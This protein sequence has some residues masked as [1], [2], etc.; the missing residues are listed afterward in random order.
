M[1]RQNRSL[2]A[3]LGM[4]FAVVAVIVFSAVGLYLYRALDVQLQ[5]RDD[6]DLVD[7]VLQIRHLLGETHGTESIRTEPHRFLDAVD[8]RSGLL[9]VI[10]AKDGRVLAQNSAERSFIQ[11]EGGLPPEAR[12]SNAD[13]RAAALADGTRLRAI[14]AFGT[15]GGGEMVRISLARTADDRLAVLF[16]Y[17]FKVWAAAI[18]GAVL[19]AALGYLLVRQGLS[20]VRAMAAQAQQVTAHNLEMRLSAE[21]APAELRV[22]ADSFNA[23]LDRLQNSFNHLSQF[24]D[25]LAH[26]L[27]TPLNNLMVQTEVAF[28]QPRQ[29]EEYQHLLSSNYEEFGRLARMVESML[30]L[31]RADHDQVLL[32]TEMLDVATELAMI[33]EYFEGPASEANVSFQITANGGVL[34]DSQ[35]LRRAVSNLVANA[36]RYTPGHGVIALGATQGPDGVTISVTN[37]GVG[38]EADHLPRLFDRFYRSDKARSS[39]SASAGL[40]LAIVKSIMTLHGGTASVTSSR[41]AETTFALFFPARTQSSR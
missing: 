7:S 9:L 39:K 29:S 37:P 6:A 23:V 30:F 17:R 22:L 38:I 27:R 31:A 12:L 8:R 25:D 5:D 26:D 41:D 36:I 35:L 14:T 4:L 3:Q 20:R 33:A 24:A 28:S 40:G 11:A 13:T 15:V 34:A 16:A 18:A 32:H 1:S 21:S 10:Q 19:T 2:T